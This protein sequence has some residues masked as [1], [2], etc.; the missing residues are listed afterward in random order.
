M[1]LLARNGW[2]LIRAEG[3][4]VRADAAPGRHRKRKGRRD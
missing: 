4:L 3:V 1:S 2:V